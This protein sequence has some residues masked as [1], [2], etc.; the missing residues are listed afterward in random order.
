M[1][2]K[3]NRKTTWK[4]CKKSIGSTL[5]IA[6]VV[7]VIGLGC[8][9]RYQNSTMKI[10]RSFENVLEDM[11]E[12]TSLDE[13]LAQDQFDMTQVENVEIALKQ[14]VKFHKLG[15]ENYKEEIQAEPIELE[16]YDAEKI[17]E[18]YAKAKSYA[19]KIDNYE[20]LS[21]ETLEFFQNL[22]EFLGAEDTVNRYLAEKGYAI[23]A[24]F[25]IKIVRA[26]LVDSDCGIPLENANAITLEPQ[27]VL[28]EEIRLSY[29]DSISKKKF[30]M[31]A[32]DYSVIDNASSA[33]YD[34]VSLI[35]LLQTQKS[36][37]FTLSDEACTEYNK[38]RIEVLQNATNMLKTAIYSD[39]SLDKNAKLRRDTNRLEL[40]KIV[41]R[42][43][44]E[45]Q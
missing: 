42:K 14:A 30:T 36:R 5:T 29:Q 10:N 35:Y 44:K 43:I 22:P 40:K 34:F 45:K 7:S 1:K 23:F 26:K 37:A 27:Q 32:N 24:E 41:K 16:E 28:G 20:L 6:G 13:L 25:A 2:E 12:D 8:F 17:E 15:L 21:K 33:A 39:Y 18:I 11:Q 9:A 4:K 31:R 3:T 19:E 38:D